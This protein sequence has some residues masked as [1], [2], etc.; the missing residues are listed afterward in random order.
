MKQRGE[1]QS[2]LKE[3]NQLLIL[4]CLKEGPRSCSDLARMT[5]LSY[6][7]VTT[8]VEDL[9]DKGVVIKEDAEVV[10]LGRRP[11]LIKLAPKSRVV[12]VINLAGEDVL[13]IYGLAGNLL[14]SHVFSFGNVISR[15]NLCELAEYLR[16]ILASELAG[17]NL[18]AICIAAPGKIDKNSGAFVFAP[19]IEDYKEVNLVRMFGDRFGVPVTVK[20]NIRFQ[21]LAEKAYGRYR[22]KICDTLFIQLGG[23]GFGSA[24]F[25]NNKLY[26]GANGL[27]GEIG[28]FV[29]DYR[30]GILAHANASQSRYFQQQV[31]NAAFIAAAKQAL[32]QGECSCLESVPEITAQELARGYLA[33]DRL[34]CEILDESA[35]ITADVLRSLSEILDFSNVIISRETMIY[36]QKYIDKLSDYL[37]GQLISYHIDCYM[38]TFD[39]SGILLGAKEY[40]INSAMRRISQ[41]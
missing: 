39:K 22:D 8:L 41:G 16:T 21:L 7:G 9:A 1:N 37:N 14:H 20:N 17:S 28:L 15:E 31:S 4:N 40:A 2:T 12:A 27:N 29:T 19:F 5:D 23:Q 30:L 34:C 11:I 33:D 13:E 26:E 38:S 32:A 36:G 35:R 10:S 3:R 25:L 6:T 24:L 18:E